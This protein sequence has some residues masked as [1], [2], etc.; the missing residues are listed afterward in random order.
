VG[1]ALRCSATGGAET[2]Q[3]ELAGL[4]ERYR[5]DE[6]ILTGNIH[7]P[8]ARKRSFAIAAAAMRGIGAAD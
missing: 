6:V 1:E 5:P 3:R 7:D 2:V 8:G 4:I